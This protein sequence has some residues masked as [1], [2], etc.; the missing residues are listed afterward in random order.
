MLTKGL[1]G[2]GYT[3]LYHIL[4][5]WFKIKNFKKKKIFIYTDSRGYDVLSRKGKN[6]FSS[7]CGEFIKKYNTDYHICKEK[8]TTILDFLLVLDSIDVI[9]YDAIILHCGVVDFSPRP[10]SNLNWVLNSK[11]DNLYFKDIIDCDQLYYKTPSE[12]LYENE[13]VINLYSKN[14]LIEFIIPRLRKIENL[15]WINSN[16]FIKGWDGNYMKGRP[17]NIDEFVNSFDEIMTNNIQH[18]IN[19][20]KWKDHDIQ[21]FTIDNIHFTKKGF[22]ELYKMINSKIISLEHDL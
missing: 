19:L 13:K 5:S 14:S 3:F 9:K 6:P 17:S 2:K 18:V 12:T 22:L 1:R 8:H 16:R 4:S 15:I 11:K 21:E 10:L 7:Y 20:K